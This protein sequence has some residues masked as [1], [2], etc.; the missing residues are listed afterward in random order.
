MFVREHKEGDE[1]NAF[2]VRCRYDTLNILFWL[3]V[4]LITWLIYNRICEDILPPDQL[5]GHSEACV[6]ISKCEIEIQEVDMALSKVRMKVNWLWF[7][8][9]FWYDFHYV[10]YYDF[11]Y[12]W[13]YVDVFCC[14]L[15]CFIVYYAIIIDVFAALVNLFFILI[16]QLNESIQSELNTLA[17]SAPDA[18]TDAVRNLLSFHIKYHMYSYILCFRWGMISACLMRQDKH[19][20]RTLL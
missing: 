20:K 4:S 9:W 8:R 19:S 12:D 6:K 17:F 10:F 13:L 15:W 14:L 7:S 1:N 2:L 16:I 5:E 3:R 18:Y 11:D